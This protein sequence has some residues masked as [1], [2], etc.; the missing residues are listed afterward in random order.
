MFM[1]VKG[2]GAVSPLPRPLTLNKMMHCVQM[3]HFSAYETYSVNIEHYLDHVKL[4][5]YFNAPHYVLSNMDVHM[6]TLNGVI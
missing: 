1:V 2:R 3:V 6:D 5:F 4:T